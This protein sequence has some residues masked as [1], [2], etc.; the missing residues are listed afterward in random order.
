MEWKS[1]YGKSS[2]LQGNNF[3]TQAKKGVINAHNYIEAK[4]KKS[5]A[6]LDRTIILK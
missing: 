3:K 2:L 4:Q 6:H 1:Q 5:G